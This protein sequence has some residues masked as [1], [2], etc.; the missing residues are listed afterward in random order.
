[1]AGLGMAVLATS[2]C[3]LKDKKKRF[4]GHPSIIIAQICML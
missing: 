1:M 3:F 4:T 2:I